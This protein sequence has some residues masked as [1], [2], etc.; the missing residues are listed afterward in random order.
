MK[1]LFTSLLIS[2]AGLALAQQPP[3][4]TTTITKADASTV[5]PQS[6]PRSPTATAL[7]RYGEY[8]VGLYTGVPVIEIPIHAFSVGGLT[9]PIKLT[10]HAAGHKV[11]DFASW[12]GLGWSLQTGGMISRNVLGLPDEQSGS[13][14]SGGVTILQRPV[15]VPTYSGG[16]LTG[17]TEDL[18]GSLASNSYDAQ[19]DVF[20]YQLPSGS[21]NSFLLFPDPPGY[22]LRSPGPAKITATSNLNSFTIVDEGGITY[23]FANGE[24]VQGSAFGN[25]QSVW[26]VSEIT[27]LNPV[28]R[29]VYSY[30]TAGLS[31]PNDLTDQIYVTDQV[32]NRDSGPGGITA[33][34]RQTALNNAISV[35]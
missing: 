8:P 28:D 4:D 30:T 6:T 3:T 24:T 20:G 27:G 29:A 9:I 16:C 21:R 13:T 26:Y 19:R 5:V 32:F 7:G 2:W 35:F 12:V 11:S 25:Y 1:T 10:Y 17:T 18:I 33:G 31:S 22:V 15:V 23:R 34:T 14:G